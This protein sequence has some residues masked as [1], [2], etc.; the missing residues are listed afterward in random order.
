M[1]LTS[2]KVF[3]FLRDPGG[4]ITAGYDRIKVEVCEDIRASPQVWEEHTDED[5][6]LVIEADK[7]NY[8]YALNDG[9]PA[10]RYRA[11][12]SDSTN[13]NADVVQAPTQAI[14]TSWEA[15]ITIDEMKSIW[16]F[17]IDLTGDDGTPYPDELFAHFISA[18]I[19]QVE[20]EL[21]IV[22]FA[23]L[24]NKRYD[25]WRNEWME[26]GYVKLDEKP[27][28][29]IEELALR[30]PNQS[31]PES[32]LALPT[33]WI[34]L[35]S[36]AGSINVYPGNGNITTSLL[37]LNASLVSPF[38]FNGAPMI[39]GLINVKF[40]A[41]MTPA[42]R[43][44]PLV[45]EYVGKLASMGPL[46]I[47]GDLVAGAGIAAQSISIDGLSRS[48]TTSNS[49]TNAGYGARILTWQKELKGMKADMK[50][51]F[52]GLKITAV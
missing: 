35:D 31:S 21:D 1:S 37:S 2:M 29:S 41:G 11:V 38:L 14:D 23:R 3:L 45:K 30:F 44:F 50:R 47:A 36:H 5:T 18:A 22:C 13:V 20:L 40:F 42:D 4:T 51:H 17:S 25:W 46:N 34:F 52:S 43:R 16:L 24:F 8:H 49:S 9:D 28:I 6:R 33:E 27:V 32:I 12:I 10:Y 26:F 19:A 15:L 39:P 7:W 48:I